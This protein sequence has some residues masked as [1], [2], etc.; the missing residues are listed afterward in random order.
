MQCEGETVDVL[1]HVHDAWTLTV[2]VGFGT[3]G[4]NSRSHAELQDQNFLGTG[5]TVTLDRTRDIERTTTELAYYDPNV[6]GSQWEVEAAWQS[7]SDGTAHFAALEYPFRRFDQPWSF[8]VRAGD[9]ASVLHF[10]QESETVWTARS[11]VDEQDIRLRRLLNYEGDNGWRA[12]IGWHREEHAYSNLLGIHPA[13]LPKPELPDRRLSGAYVVIERFHEH[14]AGFRNIRAMDRHEDYNL[15]FNFELLLGNYATDTGSSEDAPFIDAR[16]SYGS[17]LLGNGL[18]LTSSRYT[19]RRNHDGFVGVAAQSALTAYVNA[20]ETDTWVAR[21]EGNWLD[22]PDPEQQLYIGGLEALYGYPDHFR[23]GSANWKA[24]LEY[25]RITDRVL[26]RTLRVG[27]SA[28]L[29]GAQARDLGGDWGGTFWSAGVALR[30]GNLRGS[31]A[32]TIY[33]GVG[34]P[35]VQ[36]EG[37]E[38]WQWLVTS[39]ITF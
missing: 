34:I 25:R 11:V 23:N 2:N 15:G 9:R 37:V 31:D 36:E 14:Y 19:G 24:H 18:L 6:L 20:D 12:G 38:D 21:L 30:L 7:L 39:K 16:M 1:V 4:G 29:Q 35:L 17:R 26:F 28:F 5:K 32:E 8:S 27:Y 10:Y 22:E 33:V 13:L 3:T